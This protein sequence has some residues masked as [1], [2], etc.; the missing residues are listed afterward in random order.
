MRIFDNVSKGFA[1]NFYSLI[2]TWFRPISILFMFS[3]HS[4]PNFCVV[5]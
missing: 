4:S 3:F 2:F 1:F 5:C